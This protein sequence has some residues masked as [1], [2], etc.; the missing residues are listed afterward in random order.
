MHAAA[1]FVHYFCICCACTVHYGALQTQSSKAGC[2]DVGHPG[3]GRRQAALQPVSLSDSAG[4]SR[5][6]AM[7]TSAVFD[8][9]K[10]LFLFIF[11]GTLYCNLHFWP[12]PCL[13]ALALVKPGRR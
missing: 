13:N 7:M 12:Y 8:Y 11:A 1:L 6:D 3:A 4:I 5:N 9:L 2:F 10:G